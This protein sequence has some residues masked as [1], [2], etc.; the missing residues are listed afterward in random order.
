VTRVYVAT[1]LSAVCLLAAAWLWFGKNGF[2]AGL[3]C[4][5]LLAFVSACRWAKV[6]G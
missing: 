5:A 4:V 1:A 2:G 6:V 3:V